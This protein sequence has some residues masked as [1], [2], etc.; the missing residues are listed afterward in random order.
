MGSAAKW[1]LVVD[2]DDDGREIVVEYL[3]EA[4]YHARGV[5]DC[6]EALEVLRTD[7]PSLVLCDLVM[8][9]MDGKEFL[10]RARRQDFQMP[11]LV[12]VTGMA[13]SNCE[14]ISGAILYKPF[15]PSQLLAV[16]AHHCA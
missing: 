16:V 3:N 1:V 7:K 4:G 13:P 12:F 15:D 9:D 2:D 11:P 6:T 5:S 10:I 14:D 8:R